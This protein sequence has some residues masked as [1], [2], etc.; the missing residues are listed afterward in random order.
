MPVSGKNLPY[1]DLHLHLDGAIT[2]DI[3]RR[4][5]ALQ[6]LPLPARDDDELQN[7]LSLPPDCESLDDFLRCFVLPL[8]LLQTR[9][10]ISE[11]VYLVQEM[12]RSQGV[13]YGELR[14]AP[15]LHRDRGLNQRQ[16]I[17]AALEGLHRSPLPCG[18]IL[19]CMRGDASVMEANRETVELAREF[20]TDHDGVVALD[21]AG[22]EGLFPTRDYEG[23]FRQ[24]A[25]WGIPFTIH[26]GEADGP[27]SVRCALEFGAR[28]IGHGVRAVQDPD[29]LR[30]IR[31]RNIFLEIC[32]TSNRQ[33][34]AVE[35]MNRYPLKEFLA[36]GISVTINTDDMA[37]CRT[38]MAEE[39]AYIRNHFGIT[40]A[41]ENQLYR[42]AVQAAFSDEA[43][44]KHLL[45]LL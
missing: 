34:R 14:F 32:P 40:A 4:L 9:E 19:C 23:L 31:E 22:A 29:L 15:Q 8:T 16:V 37:I 24:A 33:T 3:A 13:V 28:R 1:I 21:L 43:T 6:K 12:I 30:L 44:K 26:A 25:A 20:L 18:L 38:T 36:Q 27:E 39:F 35:D 17:E 5:A 41:E 45:E 42:N 11:A 2:V 7:L 10:G